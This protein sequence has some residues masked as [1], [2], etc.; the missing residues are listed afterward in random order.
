M[1]KRLHEALECHGRRLDLL[2]KDMLGFARA[3]GLL[4]RNIA[5]IAESL[6]KMSIT[7]E[8]AVERIYDAMVR[9][10]AERQRDS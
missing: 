9:A 6:Q 1:D 8:E 3:Y 4:Y 7:P 2:E 5:T 10:E